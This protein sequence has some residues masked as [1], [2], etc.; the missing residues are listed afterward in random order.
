MIILYFQIILAKYSLRL[1]AVNITITP[2]YIVL[3][4]PLS[5][6]LVAEPLFLFFFHSIINLAA[7]LIKTS[8]T[9]TDLASRSLF[10]PSLYMRLGQITCALGSRAISATP[11]YTLLPLLLTE[12]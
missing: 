9:S 12:A 3:A 4:L 11:C 5:L 1:C 8:L 2:H 10:S 6:S 7:I